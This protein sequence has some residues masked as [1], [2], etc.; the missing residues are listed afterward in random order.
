MET[1]Y[2][3][4]LV[5]SHLTGKAPEIK[6][7]DW[8]KLF[9]LSTKQQLHPIIFEVL[10]LY[11]PNFKSYANYSKWKGS[12]TANAFRLAFFFNKIKLLLNELDEK[13]ISV[14]MLKGSVYRE[15]YPIPELRTMGDV[16]LIIKKDQV[17]E[18]ARILKS[19]NF[20]RKVDQGHLE[21]DGY[22]FESLE[23]LPGI[24][25]FFS[26]REDFRDNFD[27]KYQE[28]TLP[29]KEFKNIVKL[30]PLSATV[31][32]IAHFAKHFYTSGAG[33]RFLSDL[34]LLLVNHTKEER[35][36]LVEE[37]KKLNLFKFFSVSVCT[38]V[39]YFG[40]AP[41]F[42]YQNLNDNVEAFIDYLTRDS[43]YGNKENS[44]IVKRELKKRGKFG[45]IMRTAF[46]DVEFLCTK[47]PY[48]KNHKWLLP[49]AWIRHVFS[50]LRS[51]RKLKNNLKYLTDKESTKDANLFKILQDE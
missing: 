41:D 16:D 14:V 37:I 43:V 20:E 23:N 4:N 17:D 3:L 11:D 25:A 10:D 7:C 42:D 49:I 12:F 22:E 50:I 34:Y 38:L 44:G 15:L 21:E 28:D 13:N 9:S 51:P 27:P 48:F 36:K 45:I 47:Y 26:L 18:F 35:I 32:H 33:V 29:Y 6:V 46:P 24:E 40:Y 31:H 30:S 8:D 5:S 1:R 19:Y 2:L 39:K